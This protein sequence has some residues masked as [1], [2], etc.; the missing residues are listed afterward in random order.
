MVVSRFTK[1]CSRKEIT[2]PKV[3]ITRVDMCLFSSSNAVRAKPKSDTFGVKSFSSKILLD[4]KS[5]CMTRGLESSCK[6]AKP[7]AAP[8]AI[9]IRGPQ[10]SGAASL[11]IPENK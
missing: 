10:L 3:P 2:H 11:S 7:R 5:L 1:E 4:L 8:S 6:Y 9:F